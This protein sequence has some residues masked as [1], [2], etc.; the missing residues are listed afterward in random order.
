MLHACYPGQRSCGSRNG[1]QWQTGKCSGIKSSSTHVSLPILSCKRD[2]VHSFLFLYCLAAEIQ[3]THFSS[4]IFL[5]ER[6]ST[7]VSLPILSCGRDTVHSFRFLYCLAGEIQYTFLF[8]YCLAGEIQY[9]RFVSYIFL[10]QRYS[11]LVSLPILSCRRDT[12]LSP[13]EG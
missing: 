10:Q 12:T 6:Y 3:Y 7:L 1:H 11:T 9:T 2:T 4:C 8:L 5:Q 13:R